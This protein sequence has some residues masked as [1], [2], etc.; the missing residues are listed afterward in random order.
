M[1]TLLQKPLKRELRVRD[2]SYIITVSPESLKLTQKGRRK[3]YEVRWED[4]V[5]GA[6]ALA[7]A[8][9][10]SIGKF[11]AAPGTSA[12]VAPSAKMRTAPAKRR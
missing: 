5:S 10:A 4:L 8:L 11:P 7:T 2:A 6:A 12:P 3:G 9:N 1:V